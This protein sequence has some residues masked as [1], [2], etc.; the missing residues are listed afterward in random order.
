LSEQQPKKG[1]SP[2]TPLQ[3]KAGKKIHDAFQEL[4]KVAETRKQVFLVGVVKRTDD[5]G[6]QVAPLIQYED[7]VRGFFEG[8]RFELGELG[9]A[10][11]SGLPL[12][13]VVI[14][15]DD[16]HTM[17]LRVRD[18]WRNAKDLGWWVGQEN[19][20]DLRQMQANAY[21]FIMATKNE[22]DGLRKFFLEAEEGFLR[23][24]GAPFLPV[25]MVP[26]NEDL[27]PKL[28]PV[29][30]KMVES[31]RSVSWIERFRR[32]FK[33][34]DPGLLKVWCSIIKL[35]EKEEDEHSRFKLHSEP[36]VDKEQWSLL[37]KLN[38]Q[39]RVPRL[40]TSSVVFL[41]TGGRS[42]DAPS[43]LVDSRD[44]ADNLDAS[45]ATLVDNL[46]TAST[47]AAG[48]PAQDLDKRPEDA[49]PGHDTGDV[50]FSN[51]F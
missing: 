50:E 12:G 34:L 42:V 32:D 40:T 49:V 11:S 26:T 30:L 36:R 20:A 6:L 4:L 18:G 1:K 51:Y 45:A 2:I 48:D 17:K 31:I 37:S 38:A 13:R 27:W 21:R 5:K 15:P 39:G 8:V 9:K 33:K 3:D 19:P 28:A 35:D 44:T 46:D 29:L 47:T 16:V 41:G 43:A 25:Y 14:H 7:F 10:Q 23:F 22:C 24:Q